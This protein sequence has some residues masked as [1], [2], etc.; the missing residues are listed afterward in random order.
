MAAIDTRPLGLLQRERAMRPDLLLVLPYLALSA[1]GLLMVYT[2]SASRLEA[3]GSDP[4]VLMKRQAVFV[5]VGIVLFIGGLDD[6]EPPPQGEGA[7]SSTW[8]P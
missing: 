2:A 5:V 3:A 1:F 7:R 6:R 8:G 4:G